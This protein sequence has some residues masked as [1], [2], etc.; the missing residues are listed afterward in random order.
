MRHVHRYEDWVSYMSLIVTSPRF[1]VSLNRTGLFRGHAPWLYNVS[2]GIWRDGCSC[3]WVRR[4]KLEMFLQHFQ[5]SPQPCDLC[6][7][8]PLL[9]IEPSLFAL[10]FDFDG[11][12]HVHSYFHSH[13]HSHVFTG[14]PAHVGTK[15]YAQI[16]TGHS[17][18]LLLCILLL[19]HNSTLPVCIQPRLHTVVWH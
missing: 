13:V 8:S 5:P 4:P 2:G 6:L 19:L 17:F 14:V 9:R 11:L 3:L 10:T 12:S 7:F 18:W 16:Y 1:V 15:F